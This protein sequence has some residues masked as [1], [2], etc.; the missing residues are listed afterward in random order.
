MMRKADGVT[1]QKAGQAESHNF[2]A[3]RLMP[4]QSNGARVAERTADQVAQVFYHLFSGSVL[5][6]TEEKEEHD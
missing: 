1:W 4:G 5:D 6:E 3:Q 2:V